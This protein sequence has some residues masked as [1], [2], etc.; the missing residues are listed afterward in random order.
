MYMHAC[1]TSRQEVWLNRNQWHA[2]IS[3]GARAVQSTRPSS[4]LNLQSTHGQFYRPECLE[5]S[6]TSKPI[7]LSCLDVAGFY[8]C[9]IQI[10]LERRQLSPVQFIVATRGSDVSLPKPHTNVPPEELPNIL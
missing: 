3:Q 10:C 9:E 6:C 8:A 5:P 2:W 1:L 4:I 7:S